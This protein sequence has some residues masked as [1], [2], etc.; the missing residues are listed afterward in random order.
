MIKIDQYCQRIADDL[1]RFLTLDI[2]HKPDPARVM[3][4]AWIMQIPAGE[5]NRRAQSKTNSQ[6]PVAVVAFNLS[7]I[8]SHRS[9]VVSQK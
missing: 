8:S 6:L 7:L 1:V 5:A 2:D 9:L 4:I 3:L